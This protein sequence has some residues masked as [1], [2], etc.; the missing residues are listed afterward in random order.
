MLGVAGAVAMRAPRTAVRVPV[1]RMQDAAA[2]TP[3]EVAPPPLPKIKTMR[4]GDGTLAG[5]MNF[6]PLE[7]SDSPDA[8]AWYREAEIKHARL[9]MLAA[10]GWPASEIANF[11][12]L[13]T[14]DGRAPSLLNGGL[15]NINVAYWAF[16]VAVAVFAESKGLDKQYGKK[17]NYLPGMLG[18]DP[19][20]QDS[21]FMRNAEITNGRV[22]MVA[23]TVFALE[24][25]ITKSAIFPVNLF[26]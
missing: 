13:L 21:Q 26:Q 3:E 25:A 8:L 17:D 5:D 1:L 23:I 22:A 19:L 6:D 24:E 20:G 16:V 18:F 2:V 12:K 9:A 7:I 11:G 4:V 14:A 15:G 10:F